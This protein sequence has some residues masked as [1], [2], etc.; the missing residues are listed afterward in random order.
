MRPKIIDI[1]EHVQSMKNLSNQDVYSC[2]LLAAKINVYTVC[3]LAD[4]GRFVNKNINNPQGEYFSTVS[5]VNCIINQRYSLVG[6][7]I[8]DVLSEE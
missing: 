4:R 8:S 2:V 1:L 6:D 7:T 3:N 5:C